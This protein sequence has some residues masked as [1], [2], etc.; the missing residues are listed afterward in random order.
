MCVPAVCV[1]VGH[2]VDKVPDVSRMGH[3]RSNW[4][5]GL[6]DDGTLVHP[7]DTGRLADDVL[8]GV[9]LLQL[10]QVIVL[11]GH[12]GQTDVSRAEA[13]MESMCVQ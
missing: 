4:I 13:N 2:L 9:G 12:K 6:G 5:L 10:A 7:A 1:C 11:H 8:Q 3:H